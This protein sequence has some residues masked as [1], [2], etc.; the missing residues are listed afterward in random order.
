MISFFFPPTRLAFF[1]FACGILLRSAA[2]RTIYLV[3][4]SAKC[5][6]RTS[7]VAR[8]ITRFPER[9]GGGVFLSHFEVPS[10]LRVSGGG[11]NQRRQFVTFYEIST[12]A[13]VEFIKLARDAGKR[14]GRDVGYFRALFFYTYLICLLGSGGR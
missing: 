11:G 3:A 14:A 13:V 4:L 2:H 12:S 1:W 5:T 10:L 7:K 8:I 6:A 9:R